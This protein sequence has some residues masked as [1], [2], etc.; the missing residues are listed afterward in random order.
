[1]HKWNGSAKFPVVITVFSAPNYCD[2]Y[3]NK[4]AVLKLFD[5]TINIQQYTFNLH[6]YHLPNFL[7]VFSWSIPFVIEK[8]LEMLKFILK[9]GKNVER[10]QNLIEKMKDE[11][12]ENRKIV[13]K[14]KIK[15]ISKMMKM[16]KVLREEKAIIADIKGFSSDNKIPLGLLLKGK[17]ALETAVEGFFRIKEVDSKNEMRPE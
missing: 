7:N 5:N 9:P 17:Q 13:L 2:C 6:P 15:S 16:F 10:N 3:N 4:G 8:T 1:M 14:N 12:M 11:M